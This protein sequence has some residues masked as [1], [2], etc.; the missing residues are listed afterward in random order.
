MVA[1]FTLTSYNQN[2]Y[3][4]LIDI[5]HCTKGRTVI[6]NYEQDEHTFPNIFLPFMAARA[7]AAFL[8]SKNSTKQYGSL[9]VCCWRKVFCKNCTPESP[10]PFIAIAVIDVCI[11]GVWCYIW[12]IRFIYFLLQLYIYTFSYI[13]A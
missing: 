11:F 3:I 6:L 10:S 9:L 7:A 2:N 1:Q 4:V 5:K 13:S 8:C 12:W